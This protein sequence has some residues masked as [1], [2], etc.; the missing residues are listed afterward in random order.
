[1][2]RMRD[3]SSR[4]EGGHWVYFYSGAPLAAWR[5]D[6]VPRAHLKRLTTLCCSSGGREGIKR[7]CLVVFSFV[8]VAV[9]RL[10][11]SNAQSKNPGCRAVTLVTNPRTP[12]HDRCSAPCGLPTITAAHQESGS[13]LLLLPNSC[14][15][16]VCQ[17]RFFGRRDIS[18]WNSR[19]VRDCTGAC[20]KQ[21]SMDGKTAIANLEIAKPLTLRCGRT[22]PNRLVKSATAEV[23]SS[24]SEGVWNL[25][26]RELCQVYRRWGEGGWGMVITGVFLFPSS[27]LILC[28][29]RCVVVSIGVPEMLS[30]GGWCQFCGG[31]GCCCC[32][33]SGNPRFCRDSH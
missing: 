15:L 22:L 12:T 24:S 11:Q 6:A 9:L 31:G 32:R 10:S 33:V 28:S 29:L 20:C 23:L 27:S 25:P 4:R 21:A 14:W 1:M 19:T 3:R 18:N 16:M 13:N 26:T 2:P 5:R 30:G 8:P 7:S 17:Q